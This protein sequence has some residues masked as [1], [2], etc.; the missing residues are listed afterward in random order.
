MTI[1]QGDA[2]A[3][4]I[5]IEMDAKKE[6]ESMKIK[7]RSDAYKQVTD[8]GF[9]P[10]EG[11]AEYILYTNLQNSD[12]VDLFYNIDRAFVSL[13][14]DPDSAKFEDTQNIY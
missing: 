8:L 7:A 11:L 14:W 5:E 1:I 12:N 10:A 3:K 13:K 9:T 4:A 6:A 2:N